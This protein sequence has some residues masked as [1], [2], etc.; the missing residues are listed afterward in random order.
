MLVDDD[1]QSKDRSGP[2][3]DVGAEWFISLFFLIAFAEKNI[4]RTFGTFCFVQ[5]MLT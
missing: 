3:G 5:I 1:E 2:I 4:K